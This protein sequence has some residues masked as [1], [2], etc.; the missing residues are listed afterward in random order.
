MVATCRS[1]GKELPGEFP[2]C[3]FCT[4]PLSDSGPAAG[5]EERKVV[6]VLFC[7]LVGFT[8][9][10]DQADPEDVRARLRPYHTQ[11]RRVIESHGGTVEKF[12]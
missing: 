5:R 4:A 12:V 1:C 6:S 2:F 7:D 8:A 11:L 9:A 3:P 10:S